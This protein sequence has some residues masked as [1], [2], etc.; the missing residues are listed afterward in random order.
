MQPAITFASIVSLGS[1]DHRHA[2]DL[3]RRPAPSAASSAVRRRIKRTQN[4][5]GA[6]LHHRHGDPHDNAAR[7]DGARRAARLSDHYN[8]SRRTISG[9]AWIVTKLKFLLPPRRR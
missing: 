2:A 1:G 5:R 6:D 3:P 8:A 4:R 9:F 7:A